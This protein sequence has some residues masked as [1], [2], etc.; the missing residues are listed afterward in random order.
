MV[1]REEC[2]PKRETNHNV[3]L[4]IQILRLLIHNQCKNSILVFGNRCLNVS[5]FWKSNRL[6]ECTEQSGGDTIL[7]S[8]VRSFSRDGDCI[9]FDF[10]LDILLVHSR[11]IDFDDIGIVLLEEVSWKE[12]RVVDRRTGLLDLLFDGLCSGAALL[13]DMFPL[14]T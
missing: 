2:K 8:L 5:S 13:L 1:M 7:P 14:V 3:L 10:H 9:I 11:E 6:L 12:V 4:S